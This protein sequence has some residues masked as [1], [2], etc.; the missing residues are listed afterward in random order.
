MMF[1]LFLVAFEPVD[2]ITFSKEFN[3]IEM[4]DNTIYCAPRIGT[5]VFHV[6]QPGGLR[7]ISFTDKIDY[8]IYDFY[9]TPFAIYLNN[10][11][12]IDKFYFTSG[13]KQSVYTTQR[14]T[15][16]IL[17]AAEEIV[18]AHDV[19]REL[20]F[21]DFT[22]RIKYTE[23][24]ITVKDLSYAQGTIY[25]LTRKHI[26]LFD[27][28]GNI[29]EHIATP[30]QL[31]NIFVDST[32]L[33]LFSPEKKYVY[34]YTDNWNKV[35]LKHGVTDITANNQ[36]IVILDDSGTRLYFYNKSDF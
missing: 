31:T 27:E 30:E 32:L 34:T 21:L 13:T 4:Y 16:F 7:A 6:T 3:T 8:R 9:I 25:A 36:Y 19:R 14:I 10:G 23:P 29:L 33:F 15:S 1:F 5:S 24:N 22:N 2:T 18:F 28:F 17:T 12:S 11:F 20:V 26:V 35:D